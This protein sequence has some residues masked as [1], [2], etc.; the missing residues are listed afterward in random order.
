MRDDLRNSATDL[1]AHALV[2][3]VA[4]LCVT[5]AVVSPTPTLAQTA[6]GSEP[7]PAEPVQVVPTTPALPPPL[8]SEPDEA[9]PPSSPPS[10]APEPPGPAKVSPGEAAPAPVPP[11]A[12]TPATPAPVPAAPLVQPAPAPKPGNAASARPRDVPRPTSTLTIVNGRAVAATSVAVLAGRKG[13]ARSGPLA[14]NA[15]VT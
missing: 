5:L 9:G 8:V 2:A 12:D 13:V 7:A 4:V 14:S 11:S 15:R 10:V 6:E 1:S 3:R